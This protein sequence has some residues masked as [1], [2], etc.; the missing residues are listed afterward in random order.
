MQQAHHARIVQE[1][2]AVR[3]GAGS[4]VGFVFVDGKIRHRSEL[5]VVPVTGA[6]KVVLT[7][8]GTRRG[9]PLSGCRHGQT[10]TS[11]VQIA[12]A[13]SSCLWTSGFHNS[14]PAAKVVQ[15]ASSVAAVPR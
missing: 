12:T 5:I 15:N 7:S 2:Q 11:G 1:G 14:D 3:R 4:R 6:F 8:P 9:Q 10:A 13:V